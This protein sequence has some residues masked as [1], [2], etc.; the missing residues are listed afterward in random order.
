MSNI[1]KSQPNITSLLGQQNVIKRFQDIL[2]SEKRAAAFTSAIISAVKNNQRLQKC[3]PSSVMFAAAAAASLDLVVNENLG[4]AYLVPYGNQCQF[5][6]GWKGFVQLAQ[7]SG[8][9]K[10]INAAPVYDGQLVKN[11]PLDGFQFDFSVEGSGKPIGYAAKF[12]LLNG[13]SKTLYMTTK[14]IQAHA[15]TYSKTYSSG[16]WKNNF[17]AMATKTVIKLLLSKYGPMSIEMQRAEITDQS[18][19]KDWDG[20]NVEYIDNP[21]EIKVPSSEAHQEAE[22]T[23]RI[24]SKIAETEDIEE[25]QQMRDYYYGENRSDLAELVE[26]KMVELTK[27]KDENRTKNKN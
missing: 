1:Q 10:T 25:L 9:Y 24:K 8:L 4:Y 11:D 23:D 18:I 21:N 20:E 7:R 27:P 17:E 13:F 2:G 6:L 5:Q 26:E 16:P 3:E 14:Q 15:K 12:E 19:V 22:Q